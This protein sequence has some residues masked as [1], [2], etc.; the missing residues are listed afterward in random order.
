LE[1]K[2]TATAYQV[3]SEDGRRWRTQSRPILA[4]GFIGGHH[5]IAD[6]FDWR[7]DGQAKLSTEDESTRT[8]GL[9]LVGPGVR[10]EKIIF[11]FIYKFRQRFAVVANAIATRLQLDTTP[12]KTYRERGMFLEDLSCCAE[13]CAC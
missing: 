4:T 13:P 1:V 6:L 5:L 7:E 9:F 11:C 8:P 10:H 12:L 2:R 3:A